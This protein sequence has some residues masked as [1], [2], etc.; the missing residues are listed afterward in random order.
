MPELQT[1]AADDARNAAALAETTDVLILQ[2]H[3]ALSLT[4]TSETM[5]MLLVRRC[6]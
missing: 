1:F 6:R 3:A 2:V 5:S 4:L